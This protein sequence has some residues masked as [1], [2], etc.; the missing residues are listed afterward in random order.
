MPN[1]LINGG[2]DVRIVIQGVTNPTEGSKTLTVATTSDT[3][4]ATSAPYTI[5]AGPTAVTAPAVA[6]NTTTI[7]LR[8]R[9]R[10][11]SIGTSFIASR[12]IRIRSSLSLPSQP[13]R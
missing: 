11:C 10:R 1:T 2:N 3:T 4:A 8:N 12:R 7:T 13:C 9:A 6:T 5:T